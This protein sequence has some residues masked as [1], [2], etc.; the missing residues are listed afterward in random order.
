MSTHLEFFNPLNLSLT[1]DD[2][3]IIYNLLDSFEP[4]CSKMPNWLSDNEIPKEIRNIDCF[5]KILDITKR[6]V[7]LTIF[8][9][10]S[11]QFHPHIDRQKSAIKTNCRLPWRINFFVEQRNNSIMHWYKT[12]KGREHY[13]TRETTLMQSPWMNDDINYHYG[14]HPIWYKKGNRFETFPLSEWSVKL[15]GL[16]SALVNT[17]IV[18]TVQQPIAGRRLTFSF[19]SLGSLYWNDIITILSNNKILL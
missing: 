2:K 9:Q 11:I 14:E 17:S 18:H 1:K 10:D 3:V 12:P 15:D 13:W 8:Y 16:D 4:N 7:G 19:Y 5:S 6:Q